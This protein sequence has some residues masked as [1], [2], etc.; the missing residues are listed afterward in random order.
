MNQ[1]SPGP[2]APLY[3]RFP[4]WECWTGVGGMLYARLRRSTPPVVFRAPT[5]DELAAKITQFEAAR[6]GA[7]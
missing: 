5:A 1:S 6:R 2:L 7:R 3:G 4:G